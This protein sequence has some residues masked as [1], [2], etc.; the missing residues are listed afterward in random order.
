MVGGDELNQ[1]GVLE[2]VIF[3]LIGDRNK[4][5]EVAGTHSGVWE[6]TS[7]GPGAGVSWGY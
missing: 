7:K 2:R 1:R 5:R 6:I 4:V 3:E